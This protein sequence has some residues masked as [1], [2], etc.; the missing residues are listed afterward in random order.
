MCVGSEAPCV[1]AVLIHPTIHQFIHSLIHPFTHQTHALSPK[2]ITNF[3]NIGCL[4]TSLI[5]CRVTPLQKAKV[6]EAVKS[7]KK[8]VTLAVG[9]GANDVSMIKSETI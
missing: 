3:I 2:L 1:F 8:V 4:C 7:I 5:C 6:V 9:D